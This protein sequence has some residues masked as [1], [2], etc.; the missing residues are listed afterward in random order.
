MK[1][2]YAVETSFN[3]EVAEAQSTQRR[4][5]QNTHWVSRGISSAPSAPLRALRRERLTAAFAIA[6]ATGSVA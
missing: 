1:L 4:S 3:T 5:V 2:E 6:M